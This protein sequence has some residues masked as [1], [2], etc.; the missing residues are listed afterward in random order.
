MVT[1]SYKTIRY[2]RF[3]FFDKMKNKLILTTVVGLCKILNTFDTRDCLRTFV[4]TKRS[5]KNKL[6]EVEGARAPVPRSWRRESSVSPSSTGSVFCRRSDSASVFVAI[7]TLEHEMFITFVS[8]YR[9]I[10]CRLCF[11]VDDAV[12]T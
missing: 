3:I 11:T 5:I 1:P 10:S 4:A 12:I 9:H 8:K 2:T 7:R 6:L